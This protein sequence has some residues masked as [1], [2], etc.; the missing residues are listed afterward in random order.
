MALRSVILISSLAVLFWLFATVE[1]SPRNPNP[2]LTSAA[3]PIAAKNTLLIEEMTWMEVRDAIASGSTR[4]IL[5]TGGIE[6]NGPYL[7]TGKHN[8][9]AKHLS[10]LI[11]NKLGNTLVA[12]VVPFVPE[13]SISPQSGH[14]LY[15]GTIS[16]EE[17]TFER[18]L[19]N[20]VDSLIAHGF[21]EIFLLGDS[22]GN[23]GGMDRVAK[24]FNHSWSSGQTKV[25]F[26]AEYYNHAIVEQWLNEQ[27]II[28][29]KNRPYHDD[30]AFTAQLAALNPDFIRW[31]ER[32]NKGLMS[33]NGVSL[34]PLQKT[35]EWGHMIYN[36]RADK[37]VE[38]INSL[39]LSS[40]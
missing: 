39:S 15:S 21:T 9:I 14:M 37:T 17:E 36:F 3:R 33:I 34:E 10:V 13:G 24:K 11:A 19:T 1:K 20:I 18:L 32:K 12:P 40:N 25:Y 31:K 35:I 8:P 16:V 22:G 2:E 4:V 7:I 26:V 5:P 38:A 29:D 30:F 6:Q 28:Q 23:Q 27:G